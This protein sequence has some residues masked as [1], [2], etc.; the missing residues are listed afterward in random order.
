LSEFTEALADDEVRGA[1]HAVRQHRLARDL[2][3]LDR[4]A[5]ALEELGRAHGMRL[6]ISRRIV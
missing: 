5:Q 4:E 6:A 3:T 1:D 2:V